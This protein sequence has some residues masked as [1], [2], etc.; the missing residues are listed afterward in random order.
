MKA[1]RYRPSFFTGWEDEIVYFNTL[2]ELINTSWVISFSNHPNFYRFSI[3]RK[4][5]PSSNINLMA[6]YDNG[7]NW[8]VVAIISEYDLELL[9]G[10]PEWVAVKDNE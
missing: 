8:Y 3:D 2:E 6:E 7:R 1:L 9:K 10:L 4:Y 5:A